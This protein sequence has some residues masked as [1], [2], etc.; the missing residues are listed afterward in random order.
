[1]IAKM[2][3]WIEGMEACAGKLEANQE[4]LNAAEE[5]Q[6]IPRKRMQGTLLEHWRTDRGTGI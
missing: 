1:M 4:N 2:D 3:T 5:H 6:E